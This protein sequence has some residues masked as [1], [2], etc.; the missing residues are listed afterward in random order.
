VE[1]PYKIFG[2]P[3]EL[4]E[5]VKQYVNAGGVP[6]AQ[7]VERMLEMFGPDGPQ[8]SDEQFKALQDKYQDDERTAHL[9]ERVANTR[10]GGKLNA[11]T[12]SRYRGKLL[13]LEV[14]D[15]LEARGVHQQIKARNAEHLRSTGKPRGYVD[16]SKMFPDDSP[17]NAVGKLNN[18]LARLKEDNA[19]ARQKALAEKLRLDKVAK[20]AKSGMKLVPK[21]VLGALAGPPGIAAG[22]MMDASD[23]YSA[24]DATMNPT[25]PT[26]ED[27]QRK[28]ADLMRREEVY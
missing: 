1:D 13:A 25:T 9:R 17:K 18:A 20:I 5:R 7:Q 16:P 11:H 22:L 2:A 28:L 24:V 4:M 6:Y 26:A 3:P 15:E 19:L 23:A 12:K 27:A 10:D 8:L 21:S 14:A